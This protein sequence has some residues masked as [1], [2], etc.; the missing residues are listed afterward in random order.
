MKK[1]TIKTTL[2]GVF[3]AGALFMSCEKSTF[4]DKQPSGEL[5][6]DEVW[7]SWSNTVYFYTDTYNFLRNGLARFNGSWMDEATDLAQASRSNCG[8]RSSFNVGNFYADGGSPEIIDTW[9]HYYT[10]IRKVNLFLEHVDGV[11]F[12]TEVTTSV[13]EATRTRMKAEMRF[14]RAYFYWELCLRYGAIPIITEAIDP[15]QD[16]TDVLA[17]NPRPT[18]GSSCFE[19]II[20]ELN[21]CYSDLTADT[22]LST[23]D[24]GMITQGVT[25][26]LLSRIKLYLASPYYASLGLYSWQDAADAAALF[27]NTWGNGVRYDL[28]QNTADYKKAYQNAINMR[29][30]DGNKETIFWRNDA[31]GD[32]WQNE[33]PVGYG[34]YGGLCPSQTLVD[35]YD[36]ADGSSPFSSYGHTGAPNYDADGNP[37]VNPSSSYQEQRPYDNRDPRFYATVLYNGAQWWSRNIETT[38]DGTDNPR[39]NA[40]KTTT[41]Y[42]NGKYH[43]DSQTSYLDGSKTMYRNWIF[44]RYAEILLNYAEALNE[45]QGPSNEVFQVL[46]Q[47]RNRVGLTAALSSRAD[48]Q[49]KDALRNF[50]RKERTLELA[51]EDHRWW[52]VRRW[53]VADE[54]IGRPIYGMR[55]TKAANGTL[56][57]TRTAVQER[58]FQDRFYLYPIP[59]AEIWKTGWTN[60]TG[61]Q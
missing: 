21:T 1:T 2:A 41:G 24:Y 34:G 4:L 10:G 56:T 31:A 57:Y 18:S 22:D 19:W 52:D 15:E 17:S 54:A 39:G 33:S 28:Y 30:V 7:S 23:A 26:A 20:E 5:T 50:I 35:M 11:P 59:E 44:I 32:W 47:L 13:G 53:Q 42:Y 3:I 9:S 14:F 40:Y 60:N 43:D 25:L 12:G 49:S 27:I 37:T 29:A 61:W 46:Q 48:L 55:I 16:M 58:V 45:A 8:V 6:E 38:V 36:M 51:F